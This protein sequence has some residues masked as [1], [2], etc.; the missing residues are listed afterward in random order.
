MD[1]KTMNIDADFQVEHNKL[2]K[3]ID[4]NN[5][6][7]L[8]LKEAVSSIRVRVKMFLLWGLRKNNEANIK[9]KQTSI[10]NIKCTHNETTQFR[11]TLHHVENVR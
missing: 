4:V 5:A 10:R 11:K 1:G 9:R 2:K 6:C 3:N 8:V 7:Y